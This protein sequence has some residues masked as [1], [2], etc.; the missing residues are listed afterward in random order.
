MTKE[1]T[2]FQK[3]VLGKTPHAIYG[4][5][6]LKNNTEIDWLLFIRDTKCHNEAET[7]A[8][9][10]IQNTMPVK[11]V[12]ITQYPANHMRCRACSESDT[13]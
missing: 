10:R 7:I 2:F 9:K 3:C 6:T 4:K 8:I 5:A 11:N 13:N 12:W 1:N